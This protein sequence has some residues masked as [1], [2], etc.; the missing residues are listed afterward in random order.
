MLETDT[1]KRDLTLAVLGFLAAVF[2]YW[3]YP[4]LHPLSSADS[5]LGRE[6]VNQLSSEQLTRLGYIPESGAY[7]AY[8]VNSDILNYKQKHQNINEIDSVNITGPEY[9]WFTRQKITIDERS[10]T[11][12]D[13]DATESIVEITFNEA[14][15]FLSLK[16]ESNRFPS[17]VV[18]EPFFEEYH[19][20]IIPLFQQF[21]TDP[22]VLNRFQFNMNGTSGGRESEFQQSETEI[23]ELNEED[24]VNMVFYHLR[25][26]GW[27][28][29]EFKVEDSDLI[30]QHGVDI[31][32]TRLSSGDTGKTDL[33]IDILPTG[34]L[35]NLEYS[36]IGEE[37]AMQTGSDIRFGGVVIS[38]LLFAVW[39][40]ILLFIR[41]RLRLI[42][43][44]LS[45][46]IAVLVGFLL[47]LQFLLEWIF[48]YLY[49]FNEF[50]LREI[51]VRLFALGFTG[52]IGSI[53]YF[54]TT[55]VG[56]SVTRNN[57]SEKLRTFDIIRFGNVT[58]RPV[59]LAL[60]RAVIYSYILVALFAFLYYLMPE[61]YIEVSDRF[62]SDRSVLSSITV[63]VING[64]LFLIAAQSVLLIMVGKLRAYTKKG[65]WVVILT[66]LVAGLI[67]VVPQ[68]IGPWSTD[69]IIAAVVGIAIGWIYLK[70]DFLTIFFALMLM[71]LHV[72]C[73]PGWVMEN[74]P[75][76]T[77]FYASILFMVILTG[78]GLFGVYKG[79]PINQL[80]EY[81]PDY[82]NELK[83]DER[84][85]QEL[86]IARKVQKSFLPEKMPLSN[87][88]E[89]A[90]MCTPALETGGDYYDFIEI[91]EN[92]LAVAIGDVSGKGIEAA[93]YMTFTKGVLHALCSDSV[94]TI[95]TLSKINDLFTKNARRGTFI[96]LIFG[97]L[98]SKEGSFRFSRGGH[99]P[100][101]HFS[102]K[103]GV[104]KEYRPS[105]IGLGMAGEGLFRKNMKESVIKLE[106]GDLLV[107]FTDGIVEATNS[108]GDF[109][110]DERLHRTVKRYSKLSANKIVSEISKDLYEFGEGSDLHD[111]MTAIVIKKT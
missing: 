74:S 66:A 26:T 38:V 28:A 62:R 22:N 39:I 104:L 58:N 4:S 59:G 83:K 96:S 68:Q 109:Y 89:F 27:P 37:P 43:I 88:M 53:C 60:I 30:V 92:Q 110:G 47:P 3:F 86:Q 75:D 76:S 94:S 36:F 106:A 101:L 73:A 2:F 72:M 82:I 5:S 108:R 31:A 13:I 16:N 9:Y 97:I 64:L 100:L 42:D 7:S 50:E 69:V 49:L 81:V 103:K 41:I 52:A 40:L 44:K 67:G 57:W 56:D 1:A 55:A 99:N 46:L 87:G 19:P 105:G 54:T 18:E 107:L 6:A 78:V 35:L 80:P 65:I 85:K 12:M 33:L 91:N 34:A 17:K 90:A 14:G 15:E 25:N 63:L 20:D 29:D 24:A 11:L 8:M 98:D 77:I 71:G 84:I 95:D 93:F 10:A 79:K 23:Y 61:S 45:V 51:F 32:R 70:E 102:A 111:D 48:D 21:R